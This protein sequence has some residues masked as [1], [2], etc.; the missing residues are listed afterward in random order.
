MRIITDDLLQR[1]SEL[2]REYHKDSSCANWSEM[3]DLLTEEGFDVICDENFRCRVKAFE[4]KKGFLRS[5]EEVKDKVYEHKLYQLEMQ[6]VN[7]KLEKARI[8]TLKSQINKIIKDTAKQDTI[9]DI[10]L[11][12]ISPL[13]VC[14]VG[15]KSIKEVSDRIGV[16][17]LSDWHYGM[18]YENF[19]NSYD[20]KVFYKRAEEVLN[21]AI[22]IGNRY[23][24]KELH[25]LLQGDFISSSIHTVLRVQN[26]EDVIA[27]IMHTSET[28][29]VMLLDL[30]EQFDLKVHLMTDNHSRVTADKKESIE[31]ENYMRITEWFLR[32]KLRGHTGIEFV[33]NELGSEIATFKIYDYNC[34]A[35]HGHNDKFNAVVK[36]MSLYTRDIYDYIFTSHLHHLHAEETNFTTV[37]SNGS[38]SGVDDFSNKLRMSSTPMQLLTIYNKEDGLEGIYPIKSK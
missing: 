8:Q 35:V 19:L 31:T 36:N 13:P 4:K 27:Q 3:E 38:L 28:I 30:E 10:I 11:A 23:K 18:K 6:G 22:R 2:K 7:L 17:Q 16:F 9:K 5:R 33:E 12:N 14:K 20:T 26:Q 21:K 29:A 32:A 1:A 37:M 25:V 15:M 34:C 24:I